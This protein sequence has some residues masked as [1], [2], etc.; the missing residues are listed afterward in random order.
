MINHM[1]VVPV[2]FPE[3]N[4]GTFCGNMKYDTIQI[5]LY[6]NQNI[7]KPLLKSNGI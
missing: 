7:I 5:S 4:K 1:L 2:H 6:V 3:N